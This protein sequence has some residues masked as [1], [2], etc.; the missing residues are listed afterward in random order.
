MDNF[1]EITTLILSW[2]KSVLFWSG[3][4]KSV[5]RGKKKLR[6]AAHCGSA[7]QIAL[8]EKKDLPN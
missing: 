1:C 6:M 5:D 2:L 3:R 4:L 7:L 8:N